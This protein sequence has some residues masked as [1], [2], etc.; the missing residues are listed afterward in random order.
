M[1]ILIDAARRGKEVT[2]VVEL[3]ARFDEEANI[4]WAARLEEVGA[5]VVYGVVGHKTHA[6]MALIV[7]REDGRGQGCAATCTS[8]PATTIRA[9]RACT[10]TSACSPRTRRSAPTSNE[11][12][13]QLT[14]LGHVE[15]AEA[16][17]AVAVHA[18]QARGRRRSGTKRASR[19]EGKPAR[20]I[21]KMN[22]LLEPEIIEALY[23]ASQ[24]GREDRPD[25]ARRVR[26]AA[27][28]RGPVGEH[29]RALDRRP[30]PRA[31]ARVLLPE[32]RRRGRL[33]LERRLDGPQLLPPHRARASRCST[34]S[35][36]SA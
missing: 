30:L 10:P 4:N 31:L 33:P 36:S 12:F 17:L 2:V 19:S 23:A 22:A 15:H 14:G 9:P 34:R 11:V 29:P 27:G 6:K 1:E 35:S 32:R 8:P 26:A 16:P 13:K 5:H 21:A 25:R 18:A 24:A 3:M 7:R 20:I 28:R